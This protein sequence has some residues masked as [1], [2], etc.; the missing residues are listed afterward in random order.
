MQ[1]ASAQM[2]QP[3]NFERLSRSWIGPPLNL[4]HCFL[5]KVLVQVHALLQF[6]SGGEAIRI[7]RVVVVRR[8]V[9]VDI[10]KVVAV[11]RIDRPQPPVAG[12]KPRQNLP[13]VF[14]IR[15]SCVFSYQLL[16]RLLS[17]TSPHFPLLSSSRTA[18]RSR[19][20]P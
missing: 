12:G 18:C 7:V 4:G 3:F 5:K 10:A 13:V 1:E 20:R 6:R 8:T 11:R 16:S 9:R 15:Y 19:T 2:Y 14:V 17:V